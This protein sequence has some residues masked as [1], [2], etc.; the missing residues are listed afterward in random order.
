MAE[1]GQITIVKRGETVI[2][3]RLCRGGRSTDDSFGLTMTI[4]VHPRIEQFMRSL[5]TGTGEDVKRYGRYW[6]AEQGKV[7]L[8]Y[9]MSNPLGITSMPNG[10]SFRLDR[11]GHLISEQALDGM[12]HNNSCVNLSFL[13]LLGASEGIGVNFHVNGVY[14]LDAIKQMRDKIGEAAQVFYI[15]YIKP[16]D[17]DVMISTQDILR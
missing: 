13:R 14:T 6:S 15:A 10:V 8:V 3:A 5:G 11:P 12:G 1:E 9:D 4:K 17:L 16:V 2:D 7:L